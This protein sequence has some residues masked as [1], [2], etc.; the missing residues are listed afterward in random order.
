MEVGIH[1]GR[2]EQVALGV[3]DFCGLGTLKGA[4]GHF[5]NFPVLHGDAH[6]ACARRAG[7]LG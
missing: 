1:E 3:Y 6:V 7:W 5:D 2:G 4:F